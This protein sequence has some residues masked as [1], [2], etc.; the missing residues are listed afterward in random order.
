MKEYTIMLDDTII[1]KTK[2]EL[3]DA[4]MGV[5]SGKIIFT[6]PISEFELFKS[7]CKENGCKINEI[8]E[9]YKFID[10][11]VIKELKVF[12]KDGFELKGDG[13]YIT[14]M[15]SEGFQISIIGI[16]YPFYEQE[17]PH[18]VKEYWNK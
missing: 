1:G 8:D 14:G 10:T 7:F 4:P 12:R 3:A 16:A 6:K 13:N 17:F 11:Q 18:H 15:E 5:V 9:K 2:F